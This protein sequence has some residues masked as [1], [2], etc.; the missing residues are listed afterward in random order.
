M[1]K[2]EQ[3]IWI[4]TFL[5]WKDLHRDSKLNNFRALRGVSP[6][7]KEN[8]IA[9]NPFNNLNVVREAELL[10]IKKG[11]MPTYEYYLEA[12]SQKEDVDWYGCTFASAEQRIE[13]IIKTF[14]L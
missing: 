12:N 14:A 9:P 3:R 10:L 13:A 6:C 5:G 11:G 8:Q 1:S 7:G 2:E 4:L